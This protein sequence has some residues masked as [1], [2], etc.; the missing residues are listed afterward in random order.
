MTI[1]VE[2]A[3]YKK[4]IEK[5]DDEIRY[6][7]RVIRYCYSIFPIITK[8]GKYRAVMYFNAF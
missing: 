8:A 5:M 7:T 2:A 4:M 1:T 6:N 3:T